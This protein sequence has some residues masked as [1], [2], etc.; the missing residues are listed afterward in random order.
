MGM[1][2]GRRV[3]ESQFL[4]RYPWL[5][6]VASWQWTVQLARYGALGVFTN[7]LGFLVYLTIT[8]FG[9]GSKVAMSGL[10]CLGVCIS[11][12]GNRSWVFS[13]DA[14]FRSTTIRYIAAHLMGYAINFSILVVFV[15]RLGF[16]HA[17]VQAMAILTVAMFLFMCFKLFVFPR[18]DGIDGRLS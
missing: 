6:S 4:N 7:T 9:V 3:L 10:Y 2:L 8:H 15:D 1:D 17:Y 16:S 12:F 11:F 13:S 5:A 14:S 18:S